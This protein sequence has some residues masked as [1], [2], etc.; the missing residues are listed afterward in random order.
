[1]KLLI[2]LEKNREFWF[3]LITSFAFFLLRLP[4]LFEPL[5]YGDEGIY[6]VI[7]LA[8]NHG[9]LLYRDIWDNKPPL[10]YVIYAIFHGDQSII[11]FVSLLA[12][13]ISLFLYYNLAKKLF[14]NRHIWFIITGI[15][16]ILLATP[17]LEGNIANAE[18]FS[19]PFILGGALLVITFKN[20]KTVSKKPYTICGLLLGIAF[21]FK[22]VAVFDLAAFTLY[23]IY[24]HLLVFPR[25]LKQ[26]RV[27]L[28]EL[29]P[30]FIGFLIPFII[31][32]LFFAINGALG[33]FIHSAFLA[34]VGYVNYGNKF[35]LP[36]G[37]QVIPQG[38]LI[39]KL[40]F[41]VVICLVLF[42]KRN[43]L[44]SPT[45]FILLWLTFSIFNTLFSQRPY[46]HYLL[47]L[48]SSFCLFVGILLQKTK[49]Q[50][51][52][53]GLFFIMVIY[54][55]TTFKIYGKSV[56]YYQNFIEFLTNRKDVTAFRE[57]FDSSTPRDYGLAEFLQKNLKKKDH[58]FIWGNNAQLYVL[59]DT[60]PPGRYTVAYHMT[61][62]KESI[63]ETKATLKKVKP[64][65]IVIMPNQG[66]LP[67]SL[68][69]YSQS[70]SFDKATIYERNF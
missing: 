25:E 32:I 38:L 16:A 49:T 63:N 43:R 29:L 67:Y 40:F 3:L 17:V 52:Y 24:T 57:F 34:N 10:L 2:K 9:R 46:T 27:L 58:I 50:S 1:M 20:M 22:I 6:E 66:V 42:V 35:N 5:W 61:A 54:F 4:S 48:I 44:S 65:F 41:L 59:T 13:A 51:L 12:G 23:L 60:L 62:S 31:A 64:E 33:E 18:N 69:G 11:R 19:M 30:L 56:D 36:G 37:S 39:F 26:L 7:G 21:L 53:I 45:L 15:F 55:L 14:N 70:L 68:I 47:V 8:L 28:K